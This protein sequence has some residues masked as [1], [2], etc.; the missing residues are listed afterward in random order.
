M[1]YS[2]SIRR[3]MNPHPGNQKQEN[4]PSLHGKTLEGLQHK[5][6]ETCL[7]FPTE[8]QYCHS[9]CTYC[10]R[11]FDQYSLSNIPKFIPSRQGPV[12]SRRLESAVPVKR[13]CP[14]SRVP[15]GQPRHQRRL[16]HWW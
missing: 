7:V 6:R 10:F 12:Y 1:I 16:V 9:Y 3:N 15:Q 8:G 14:N 4:V 5:Y 11:W 13:Y 2:E